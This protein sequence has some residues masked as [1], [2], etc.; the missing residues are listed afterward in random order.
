MTTMEKIK[1]PHGRDLAYATL[2]AVD[3]RGGSAQS[4]ELRNAVSEITGL[5]EG[6]LEKLSLTSVKMQMG[7]ARTG[8]KSSGHLDN[9]QRGVWSLTEEGRTLLLLEPSVAQ[10]AARQAYE[11]SWA[12][13]KREK[14][15]RKA[16]GA[17]PDSGE[18]WK[19][20]LLQAIQK[21]DSASYA[22]LCVSLLNEAGFRD[23]ENAGG[24]GEDEFVGVGIYKHHLI[25]SRVYVQCQRRA[26]S[27]TAREVRAFVEEMSI[28]ANR[29]LFITTSKFTRDA[30]K[31]ARDGAQPI[32]L[33]EGEELCYLLKEYG[34]GVKI[35]MRE[36]VTVNQEFFDAL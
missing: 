1:L 25:S 35:E 15:L 10:E 13:I 22:K 20:R 30:Q 19:D 32:D 34:L 31:V 17:S 7:W 14:A 12:Q 29:G 27:I 6:E 4:K 16:T 21:M 18:G 3:K 5:T 23:L 11:R 2:Q 9:S 8:L 36:H 28:R 24:N 26:D 33:I